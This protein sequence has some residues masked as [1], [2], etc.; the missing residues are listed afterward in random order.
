MK[1]ASAMIG[2]LCGNG[3]V[4]RTEDCDAGIGV[5]DSD[6]CCDQD[7]SFVHKAICSESNSPCCSPDCGVA[8][9]TQTCTHGNKGDEDSECHEVSF[10]SGKDFSTCPIPSVKAD[11]HRCGDGGH[12]ENGRCL[13]L[14]TLVG[15]RMDPPVVLLPCDCDQDPVA[16][17]QVCCTDLSGDR[18]CRPQQQ[19]LHEGASCILGYCQKGVCHPTHQ[20]AEYLPNIGESSRA[21]N[22]NRSLIHTNAIPLIAIWSIIMFVLL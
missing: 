15:R 20:A 7:C 1:S 21:A 19:V 8:P 4:D 17:C 2:N 12:C 13:S 11:G 14:C 22:K 6:P 18:V 16:M 9:K 5:H 10:C 3:V